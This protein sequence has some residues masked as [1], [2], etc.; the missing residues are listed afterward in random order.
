MPDESQV[1]S[2]GTTAAAGWSPVQVYTMAVVCLALGLALGYLFRG[3]QTRSA[4]APVANVSSQG[5]MPPAGMGSGKMPTLEQMKQMADKKAEPLLA[6]LK[7]DPNNPAVLIQVAKI[8]QSTHQFK[9]ATSY[10]GK[11]LQIT[12]KDAATRTEMASCMYYDNDIDG[13]ISQLQQV[14]QEQPKDA[15]S[16]FNLGMIRWKGK[17]DATGA[18]AEWRRLLKSNPKLDDA[19]K[20]QVQKLIAEA[21]QPQTVN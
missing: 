8:Y 2:H 15:N 13:A 17:N 20:T 14:L 16:M 18:I 3:S 7:S 10:Y 12:P 9:E 21:G 1:T 11:A 5:S 6:Q 4:E 19:K